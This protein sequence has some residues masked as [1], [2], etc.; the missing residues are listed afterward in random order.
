M[1]TEFSVSRRHGT[2]SKRF[3]VDRRFIGVTWLGVGRRGFQHP[4]WRRTCGFRSF[5]GLVSCGVMG[6]VSLPF[7]LRLPPHTHGLYVY[8]WTPAAFRPR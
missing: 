4:F 5:G 7:N 3:W 6:S 8:R 2:K 1:G